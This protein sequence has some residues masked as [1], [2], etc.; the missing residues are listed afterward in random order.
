MTHAPT[1]TID[2][3]SPIPAYQQIVTAMRGVLVSG[4]LEPGRRL[5]TVRE[6]AIDLGVHHNTVAEAYRTLAAEGWLDL[7]RRRG[8]TVLSRVAPRPSPAVATEFSRN[9]R[10]VT[11]KALADG[12]PCCTVAE[13]LTELA[14]ELSEEVTP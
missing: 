7:R 6:L 2:T 1:I 13:A 10:A 12:I 4:Q 14:Q 11:A 9:L 8:A 5:P 3:A